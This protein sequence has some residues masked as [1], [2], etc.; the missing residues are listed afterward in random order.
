MIERIFG[1]LIV[2]AIGPV[3]VAALAGCAVNDEIDM[4]QPLRG[5]YDQRTLEPLA[6]PV[7]EDSAAEDPVE[8]ASPGETPAETAEVRRIPM[9]GEWARMTPAGADNVPDGLPPGPFEVSF[10]A[11]PLPAFIHEI[12]GRLLDL[13]YQMG[14]QVQSAEDLVTLRLAGP[15]DGEELYSA[16]INVLASFGVQ[17]RGEEGMLY[18]MAN[19][20]AS[21]GRIPLLASGRALP[22]MP[23]SRRPI[24]QIVALE[25]L[26]NA[27]VRG[28]LTQMF[29]GN[30]LQVNEDS[31]R[32]AVILQGPPALV[33]QAI[34]AIEVL[35]QPYMRGRSVL[36]IDPVWSDASQ[37]S[38]E[39]GTML[40]AQGYQIASSPSSG[41]AM[42][43][44][45]VDAINAL[46]VFASG[47]R[48]LDQAARWAQELDVP[49][50]TEDEP[51]IF[52]YR[53]QNTAADEIA[54][55]VSQLV[56]GQ[57]ATQGDPE[58]RRD[59]REP[60]QAGTSSD[61][62]SL[63]RDGKT[64]VVDEVRNTLLFRGSARK[65]QR[66]RPL[67]AEMDMPTPMVLV[68][69]TIAEITLSDQQD[70]GVEGLLQDL[71]L[72]GFTGQVSTVGGLGLGGSGLSATFDNP[73]D[74][75][76]ILNA[77]RSS[78]RVSILSRPHL[79]VKSGSQASIDVGTEV[80]IITSQASSADFDSPDG[81]DILQE[82]SFRE[83][84]VLLTISPLV[85]GRGVVDLEI[86]QEVSE[87]QQTETSNINSPSIFT[88]RI[89]T[90][91]TARDGRALLM[92]GL[93]SE[94]RTDGTSGV[95]GLS[96]IPL[97]G[98]LFRTEGQNSSR[99]EL[100]LMLVPYVLPDHRDG[101]AITEE[102]RRRLA[103]NHPGRFDE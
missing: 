1:R 101:E 8:D 43:L 92:G 81:A 14:P 21:A 4:K 70:L 2:I 67:I 73:N 46:F 15:R 47:D 24:F 68:E 41:G 54:Q 60:G 32:N 97:F 88:R 40:L 45:P 61:Q 63:G 75:R 103:P 53:V 38:E 96:R 16:A 18:L 102:F 76:L 59:Q 93:I 36:R 49:R 72:G 28:L 37:L 17:A 35:D 33:R 82:V 50:Q 79:L 11:I 99:T 10:E 12:F 13:S 90:E 52:R 44:V 80:P 56:F 84:G 20:Q 91:L 100:V 27:Q 71:E 86:E 30:E 95:P 65:W 55:I 74:A 69:V 94:N 85:R 89:T 6:Q 77:F 64:L 22:S 3:F 25:V 78:E 58:G 29:P 87:A 23:D 31:S 51:G 5:P 42:V 26:R 62:Q 48:A 83:T 98:R 19:P 57:S 7:G 66:L 39:L 34:A 9:A